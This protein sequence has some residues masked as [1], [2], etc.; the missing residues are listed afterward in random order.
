[1]IRSV[2]IHE[3]GRPEVLRIEEV[4]IEEPGEGEVR[5]RIRAIGINRT[6]ITLRSG[7]SPAKPPLPTKIGFEAAGE[8]EAIGAEVNGFAIGDRVALVPAY[9]A[10]RYA[11]QPSANVARRLLP[12]LGSAKRQLRQRCRQRTASYRWSQA[13]AKWTVGV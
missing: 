11:H 4:E 6:E 2:R 9:A 1:M 8:I 7:R 10:N 5:I 13:L 3:F 12:R